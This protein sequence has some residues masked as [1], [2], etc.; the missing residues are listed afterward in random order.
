[1]VTFGARL[2][3]VVLTLA[4][5]GAAS[6]R[7]RT[8]ATSP[9]TAHLKAAGNKAALPAAP[10]AQDDVEEIEDIEPQANDNVAPAGA[11]KGAPGADQD[12][13]P[14]GLVEWISR[15]HAAMVHLPIAW[16]MLLCLTDIATFLL[17]RRELRKAGLYLAVLALCSCLPAAIS[18]LWRLDHLPQEPAAVAPALVHRNIMYVSSALLATLVALRGWRRNELAGIYR[19]VYMALV[20]MVT[21]LVAFGAHLGGALVY[22][23]DFLPFI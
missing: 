21:T 8:H 1:M 3:T 9:G 22:G 2:L 5:G 15:M 12:N 4:I 13:R 14:H 16:T 17:G 10:A 6:A 7:G 23:D 19:A 18:G 11:A 20:A